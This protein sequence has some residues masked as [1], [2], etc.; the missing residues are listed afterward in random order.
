MYCSQ[1]TRAA[2]RS[3]MNCCSEAYHHCR[4]DM[5]Y[6][7]LRHRCCC[8]LLMH[9]LLCSQVLWPPR[10]D[11]RL[12]CP[13]LSLAQ[14]ESMPYSHHLR[15]HH[16]RTT[17]THIP[18]QALYYQARGSSSLFPLLI[19][20]SP[21][22]SHHRPSLPLP[23]TVTQHPQPQILAHK[24][25]ELQCCSQTLAKLLLPPRPVIKQSAQQQCHHRSK[26]GVCMWADVVQQFYCPCTRQKD[27]QPPLHSCAPLA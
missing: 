9:V 26:R 23:S 10:T 20:S 1:V 2:H 17:L 24:Q 3:H 11:G 16:N 21:Q 14:K 15:N 6:E 27:A 18:K 19:S 25:R 12:S 4:F 22:P 5:M 8:L 13:G 7:S